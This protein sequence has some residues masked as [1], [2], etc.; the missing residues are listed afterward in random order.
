MSKCK[1]ITANG[2]QCK[3][4]AKE[5]SEYCGIHEAMQTVGMTSS[6][7]E[8]VEVV[9]TQAELNQYEIIIMALGVKDDPGV[10]IFSRQSIAERLQKSYNDGYEIEYVQ[11]FDRVPKLG[12][13]Q[14]HFWIMFVMKLRE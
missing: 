8:P 10:G 9:S 2:T 12:E 6:D 13:Q 11:K 7:V 3:R 5:G 14:E 1:A 4:E